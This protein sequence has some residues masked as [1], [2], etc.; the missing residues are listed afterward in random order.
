[1]EHFTQTERTRNLPVYPIYSCPICK[2]PIGSVSAG[3]EVRCPYCSSTLIAQEVSIP[4][5][6]LAGAVG[7]GFGIIFGPSIL[8]ATESGSQWLARKSRERI[9]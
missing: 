7:L 8:A 4:S 6:L 2:Y 5:W 1:M 9:K 3:Q